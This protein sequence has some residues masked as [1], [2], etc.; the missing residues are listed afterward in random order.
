MHLNQWFYCIIYE[1]MVLLYFHTLCKEENC[2]FRY[3]KL[4]PNGP[5]FDAKMISSPSQ[6]SIS[7]NSSLVSSSPIEPSRVS[8]LAKC[9]APDPPSVS[10]PIIRPRASKNSGIFYMFEHSKFVFKN[11]TSFGTT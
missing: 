2:S 1:P 4:Y 10:R 11:L 6:V 9:R 5:P 3:I 7:S 8:S